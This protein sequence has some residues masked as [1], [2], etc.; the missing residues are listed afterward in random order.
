M[1]G[2]EHS[3]AKGAQE[4]AVVIENKNRMFASVKDEHI[5]R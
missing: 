4:L 2:G 3:V 5:A 1:S